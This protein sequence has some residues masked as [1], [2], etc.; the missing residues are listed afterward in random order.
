V[1]KKYDF[2][3]WLLELKCYNYVEQVEGEPIFWMHNCWIIKRRSG[4]MDRSNAGRRTS[5]ECAA[6]SC[7]PA[8]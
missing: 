4:P 8:V 1:R 5:A 3:Q 6:I 7:P 2:K